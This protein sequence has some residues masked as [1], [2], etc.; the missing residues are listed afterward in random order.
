MKLA[1][2]SELLLGDRDFQPAAK[3]R[4]YLIYDFSAFVEFD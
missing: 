2:E 3:S 4:E 1:C